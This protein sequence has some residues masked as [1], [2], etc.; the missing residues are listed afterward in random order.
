MAQQWGAEY[1]HFLGE[2]L[3][4]LALFMDI[5]HEHPEIKVPLPHCNA[6]TQIHTTSGGLIKQLSSPDATYA[7]LRTPV[8]G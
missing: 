8:A 7:K 2:C 3:P 6:Q 1:Y 4:R 5:L